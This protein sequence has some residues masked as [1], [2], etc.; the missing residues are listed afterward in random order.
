MTKTVFPLIQNEL[1]FRYGKLTVRSWLT[2]LS[3]TQHLT[4]P[5]KHSSVIRGL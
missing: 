4:A 5:G 2:D 1:R 3:I